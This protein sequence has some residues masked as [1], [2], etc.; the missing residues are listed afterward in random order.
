MFFCSSI[1]FLAKL[2]KYSKLN[3]LIIAKAKHESYKQGK[4]GTAIVYWSD[5][6]RQVLC[7]SGIGFYTG[8][9]FGSMQQ[10]QDRMEVELTYFFDNLQTVNFIT[11]YNYISDTS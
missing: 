4:A 8:K 2:V 5:F 11:N 10:A 6:V 7:F 3:T 1:V 9:V